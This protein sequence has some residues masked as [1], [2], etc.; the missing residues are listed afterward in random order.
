VHYIN[1][2]DL[3]S[4]VACKCFTRNTVPWIDESHLPSL[5]HIVLSNIDKGSGAFAHEPWLAW[6]WARVSVGRPIFSLTCS[7]CDVKL[8]SHAMPQFVEH[9]AGRNKLPVLSEVIW[10]AMD[11]EPSFSSSAT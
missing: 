11:A 2:L 4:G 6:L 3:P 8:S 5:G 9:Q 10:E 7:D 1:T